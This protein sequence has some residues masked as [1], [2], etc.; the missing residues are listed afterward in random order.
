[1]G[2]GRSVAILLAHRPQLIRSQAHPISMGELFI[3]IL[4]ILI[5]MSKKFQIVKKL[6]KKIVTSCHLLFAIYFL[7]FYFLQKRGLRRS[8]T[9]LT[10]NAEI[11]LSNLHNN[12]VKT[13]LFRRAHVLLYSYMSIFRTFVI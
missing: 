7:P 13:P 10:K 5:L 8:T 9:F 11:I 4:C 2:V 1:M 12:R 3:P 6:L